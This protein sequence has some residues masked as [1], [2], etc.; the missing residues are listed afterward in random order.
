MLSAINREVKAERMYVETWSNKYV[1]G[2]APP[3]TALGLTIYF[4][5]MTKPT[6]AGG[7]LLKAVMV[8]SLLSAVGV[9]LYEVI[10]L[11][12]THYKH[13]HGPASA[14]DRFKKKHDPLGP[15][16]VPP[17]PMPAGGDENGGGGAQA[18]LSSRRYSP[19]MQ[20][21]HHNSGYGHPQHHAYHHSG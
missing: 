5:L 18:P 20:Q 7:R 10:E 11:T 19:H 17:V 15:G 9:L 8:L 13:L 21:Q 6:D 3:M 1:T 14:L 16:G 2:W 4:Y 12:M